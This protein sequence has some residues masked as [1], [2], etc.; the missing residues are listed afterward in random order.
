VTYVAPTNIENLVAQAGLLI[1]LTG[2]ELSNQLSGND[3]SNVLTGNAGADTLLGFGGNDTLDGGAGID[4]MAGGAGDDWYRVDSRSDL[5]LEYA[6]EGVDTLEASTTY[7]LTANVENLVLLE[8]GDYSGGGNSLANV[9]TG[10]SGNNLLSGGLGA[11]TLIGG[12]GNDTYVLSDL[13]DTLIDSGGMD[14][15]RSALSIVLQSSFERAELIGLGDVS[16]L[17]NA[18]NNTLI[19]NPGN[20]YLEG[21]AGVDILTGGAGGDG[22]YIA[23]NGAA[24]DSDTVSDFKT[25]EDLLMLDLASFGIDPRALG[26]MS[27]GMVSADS[28]VKGA[29]AR[30]LDANDY[31]VYDTAQM[32]LYIDPDGSGSRAALMAVHMT[33]ALLL[34]PDDLY[35]TI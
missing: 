10:N 7:T 31:F 12:L 11:D 3:V 22:F 9:I 21:G 5:V 34:T 30:A 4:K 18:A 26:I 1:N 19:G 23:Y 16:A 17:G 6:N 20:N 15:L 33:N 27:S 2:N 25:G 35:V 28:F 24:K 8:G 32:T 29:G 13:L 14:T